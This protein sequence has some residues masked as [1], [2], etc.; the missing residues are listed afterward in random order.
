MREQD[1]ILPDL[2]IVDEAIGRHHFRPAVAS[3]RKLEG[4]LLAHGIEDDSQS[5]IEALIA[6]VGCGGFVENPFLHRTI[7]WRGLNGV[8]FGL[9][10]V[11]GGRKVTGTVQF[12]N[13]TC[14]RLYIP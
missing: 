4:R 3:G 14:R 11:P 10:V 1:L 2:V 9:C 6:D 12:D 5:Y 7:R 8:F 13:I